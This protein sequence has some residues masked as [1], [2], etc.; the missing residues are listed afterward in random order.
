MGEN[1]R[2]RGVRWGAGAA[3]LSI[4]LAPCFRVSPLRAQ[5]RAISQ[6]SA[7]A[8]LDQY[9]VTCHSNDLRTGGLSL[10]GLSL[11]NAPEHAETWEKV[12]RKLRVG[13]M[14]PQ[15]MPHWL[16]RAMFQEIGPS[17]RFPI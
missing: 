4:L 8:L 13:A 9:C 12:I 6:V 11:A 2:R 3:A 17:R 15:G 7:Q 10:Q 16:D 5:P 1:K 14:P